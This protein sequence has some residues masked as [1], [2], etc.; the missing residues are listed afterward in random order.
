M[1]DVSHIIES[2]NRYVERGIPAGSC[3]EAILS[4]DLFDAFGRADEN[5]RAGMFEIVSYVY[6]LT[7]AGCWGSR[8][9]YSNWIKKG[10]LAGIKEQ[11]NAAQ[12][13]D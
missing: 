10:G 7:P 8:E 12:T 11:A 4:N 9:A 13:N 5:T 1:T 2:I 6:S 3:T